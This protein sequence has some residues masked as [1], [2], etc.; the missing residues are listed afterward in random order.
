MRP[1]ALFLILVYSVAAAPNW[2]PKQFADAFDRQQVDSAIYEGILRADY[3]VIACDFD[4]DSVKI[5]IKRATLI[6]DLF[7][8][9]KAAKC[10]FQ[11]SRFKITLQPETRPFPWKEVIF[12]GILSIA[13]GFAAGAGIG[14]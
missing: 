7:L 3:E 11:K 8:D 4:T 2:V 14:K 13:A 6:G 5:T 1:F 10:E 12:T 9:M